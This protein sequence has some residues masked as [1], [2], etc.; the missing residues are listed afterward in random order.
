VIPVHVTPSFVESVLSAYPFALLIIQDKNLVD[1]SELKEISRLI[2][3]FYDQWEM[4]LDL[5]EKEAI[6]LR[7]FER[8]SFSDIAAELG[9]E[10]HSS[11]KRLIDHSVK[12]IADSIQKSYK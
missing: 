10:N 7:Y 5:L 11:A 9:Y 12:R 3:R 1:D 4:D 8:K 6:E 2:V